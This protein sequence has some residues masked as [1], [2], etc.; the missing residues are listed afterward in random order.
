MELGGTAKGESFWATHSNESQTFQS[1]MNETGALDKKVNWRKDET[2][3]EEVWTAKHQK[4]VK[5]QNVQ[6]YCCKATIS[7][8][9]W[10]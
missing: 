2:R 10:T 8:T 1:Y 9:Q 7:E 3:W 4:N 6:I 5:L